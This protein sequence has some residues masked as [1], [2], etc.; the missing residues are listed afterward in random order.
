MKKTILWI[1]LES[2]FL[3]IF[4]VLFFLLGGTQHPVSVWLS[5]GF[6]HFAYLMMLL[7]P[8]FIRPS[9]EQYIFGLTIDYISSVYFFSEFVLGTILILISPET[10][11]FALVSQIIIAG[12]YLIVLLINLIANEHTTDQLKEHE[13]EVQFI[14]SSA[15]QIASVVNLIYDYNIRQEVKKVYDEIK[16]SPAKSSHKVTH[17]EKRITD[18][19]EFLISVVKEKDD[20]KTMLATNNILKLIHERNDILKQ[21]NT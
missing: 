20:D 3:I 4:N 11:K 9:R 19:I 12:L 7:T 6:I 15:Q 10:F 18:E 8:I 14:K 16:S 2:I 17:I 5:Y 13:S 21:I 1:L